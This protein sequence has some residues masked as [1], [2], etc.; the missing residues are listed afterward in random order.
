MAFTAPPQHPPEPPGA[1]R[2]AGPIRRHLFG[3]AVIGPG[4]IARRFAE[5]LP[6]VGGARLAGVWARDPG[7]AQRFV[8]SLPVASGAVPRVHQCLDELLADPQVDAVYIATPHDSHAALAPAGLQHGKPVLC[9]KP[10]TPTRAQTEALL[11]LAQQRQVFLM[12]ALWTRFLP[13]YGTVGAWLREGLLGEL[14][15]LESSFCFEAP[16]DARSRL[17]NPALAGG[18]LLDIGIYNLAVTRLALQAAW[19]ACPEPRAMQAHGVR[20]PTGVD[21][22]VHAELR[23]APPLVVGGGAGPVAGATAGSE[24]VSR[25]TCAFDQTADNGFRI[26]GTLGEIRIDSGFWGATGAS[27]LRPGQAPLRADCPYERN[28]FEYQI[29]EVM[30]CIDAGLAQSPGM[31]HAESLALASWLDELRRQMGVRYPFE[32]GPGSTA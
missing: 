23:F 4:A 25:F 19:G 26:S 32:D 21:Q 17:F 10:L 16:F 29:R 27:L 14:K 28:G 11:M 18:T 30:R 24:L 15:S 1:G 3:W 20:A 13:V 8:Q 9:E 6:A 12:E 2:S 22:R 7:R 5:A 31:P